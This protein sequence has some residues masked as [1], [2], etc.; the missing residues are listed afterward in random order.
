M[1]A[2]FDMDL[3]N[4]LMKNGCLKEEMGFQELIYIDIGRL[5][6]FSGEDVL[7]IGTWKMEMLFRTK[8][9]GNPEAK[10]K[11]VDRTSAIG[12]LF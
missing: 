11:S 4:G 12:C 1:W 7:R 5:N 9:F 8:I 10:V 6:G 3:V 2:P